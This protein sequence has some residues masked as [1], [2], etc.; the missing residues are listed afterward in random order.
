[1]LHDLYYAK[2]KEKKNNKIYHDRCCM[3]IIPFSWFMGNV[4]VRFDWR[5]VADLFRF[6]LFILIVHREEIVFSCFQLLSSLDSANLSRWQLGLC[7]YLLRLHWIW[8]RAVLLCVYVSYDFLL[9]TLFFFRTNIR[10][11]PMTCR[12]LCGALAVNCFSSRLAECD[13]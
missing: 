13:A 5:C 9:L 3:V 11:W 12:Q 4:C 7:W 6:Y 2:K 1:M 8:T 10:R